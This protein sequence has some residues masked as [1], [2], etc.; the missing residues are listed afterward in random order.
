M[1]WEEYYS[2]LE[3]LPNRLKKS[4]PFVVES[5]SLFKDCNVRS[6]LDLGCGAGRHCVFLAKEDFN[7]VGIDFSKS[8]LK[9]A[10]K[11]VR[12]EKLRNIDLVCGTMTHLPFIANFFDAVISVSVI[13]H[14][15]KSEITNA[16]REIHRV[17][18]KKGLFLAN[19]ASVEDHRFGR[20]EKVE[21]GTFRIKE[22]FEEHEFEELHHFF[23]KEE[24]S[25]LLED[26]TKIKVKPIKRHHRY[27]K[28]SAFK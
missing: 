19:L 27:W 11:W 25:K 22:E 18:R 28:V 24:A 20:G 15:I 9:M 2:S 5:L 10:K 16:V 8:S 6:V 17:L 23:T 26:F 21:E 7:V 12:K 1:V 4:V 14:A 13:H 3:E